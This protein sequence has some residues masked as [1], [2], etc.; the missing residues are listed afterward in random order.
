MSNKV[1]EKNRREEKE[2]Y[3]KGKRRKRERL[4][5][6]GNSSDNHK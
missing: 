5:Q 6:I 1:K 2:G 4:E 3:R